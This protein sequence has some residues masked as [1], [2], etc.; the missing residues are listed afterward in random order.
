MIEDTHSEKI[1]MK[2]TFISLRKHLCH[3]L[4]FYPSDLCDYHLKYLLFAWRKATK[5]IRVSELWHLT[6]RLGFDGKTW[7]SAEDQVAATWLPHG[8][9]TFI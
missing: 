8:S 3:L 6:K 4:A 2:N 9:A 1:L 7:L 5:G